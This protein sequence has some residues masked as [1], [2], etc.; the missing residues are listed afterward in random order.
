METFTLTKEMMLSARTYMPL[1]EKEGLAREIARASVRP[2][3]AAE[4]NR[5]ADKVISL[6]VLHEENYAV[7][8]MLLLNTL[9]GWYFD[10]ELKEEED[11]WEVYDYYAGGHI[12]NQI[13]RF[14]GDRET[15]DIAFDLLEDFREF[16]KMVDAM[17]WSEKANANDPLGRFAA[18]VELLSDPENLKTLVGE[19]QITGDE[20]S[21]KLREAKV[22]RPIPEVTAE[23]HRWKN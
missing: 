17:I 2:M 6:P 12:F 8:S 22:L 9:L 23:E 15:K 10:I 19:L 7:K 13:E 18:S 1:G 14:K 16:K 5:P 4:Q 3:E 21:E 11:P 20:L